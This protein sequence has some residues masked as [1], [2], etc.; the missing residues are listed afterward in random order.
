[1][2][3]SKKDLENYIHIYGAKLDTWPVELSAQ[4]IESIQHMPEYKDALALDKVMDHMTWPEPSASMRETLFADIAVTPQYSPPQREASRSHIVLLL[5]RSGILMTCLCMFL[6]L[7]LTSGTYYK[8]SEQ[9]KH[10]YQYVYAEPSYSYGIMT[11][12]TYVQ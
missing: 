4:Q 2:E 8:T 12:D 7:G 3:L 6:Y 1:M 11:G 5:W 9:N 10:A